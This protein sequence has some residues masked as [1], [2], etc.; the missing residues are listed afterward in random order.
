MDDSKEILLKV[1]EDHRAHQRHL[2]QQRSTISNSLLVAESAILAFSGNIMRTNSHLPFPLPV[3]LLILSLFGIAITLKLSQRLIEHRNM[4]KEYLKILEEL[5]NL[6][7][8]SKIEN[9]KQVLMR[10]KYPFIVMGGT[11]LYTLWVG[12][13]TLVFITG[14]VLLIVG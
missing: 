1:F 4:A 13:H 9:N 11:H 8:I 7:I 12:L 3:S 14:V 6:N 10:V 5:A 2:E